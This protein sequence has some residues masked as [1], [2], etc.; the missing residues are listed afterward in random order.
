VTLASYLFAGAYRPE[1]WVMSHDCD[2]NNGQAVSPPAMDCDIDIALALAKSFLVPE[3]C[4]YFIML[5]VIM[6]ISWN[7]TSICR[8]SC[9]RGITFILNVLSLYGCPVV[10]VVVW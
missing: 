9:Q 5:L 2:V 7:S 10:L 8:L 4:L 1:W 6:L 3:K